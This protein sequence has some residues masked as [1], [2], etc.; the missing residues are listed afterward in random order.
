M[1]WETLKSPMEVCSFLGLASYY[2]RFIKYL[3][4]IA[5]PLTTLTQKGISYTWSEKQKVASGELMKWLC[6]AP[7]IVLPKGTGEFKIFSDAS[8]VRLGCVLTQREKGAAYASRQL[9]IHERNYLTRDLE[10]ETM[11][12]SL[13]IW[14]HHI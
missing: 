6:E 8:G 14:R 4:Y 3:F 10:L 11:V 7:F 9:K 13:K 12:F 5:T 1:K 2:Q